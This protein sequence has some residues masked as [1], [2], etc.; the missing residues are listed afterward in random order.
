[1]RDGTILGFHLIRKTHQNNFSFLVDIP[2]PVLQIGLFLVGAKKLK[3]K[4]RIL[5]TKDEMWF[6]W[7][8]KMSLPRKS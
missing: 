6:D 2:Q 1:M 4:N 7:H 5:A 3:K 8:D